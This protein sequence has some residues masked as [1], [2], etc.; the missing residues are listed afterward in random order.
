M[1]REPGK[2]HTGN[3]HHG[4]LYPG[5]PAQFCATPHPNGREGHKQTEAKRKDSYE[6]H[7][8][9]IFISCGCRR[10]GIIAAEC[11]QRGAQRGK[12]NAPYQRRYLCG[13]R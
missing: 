3:R 13:A 11:N 12:Q 10:H 2:V 6:I 9:E 5:D 8:D 1:N 7:Q 4:K